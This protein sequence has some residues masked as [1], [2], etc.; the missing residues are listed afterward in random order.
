MRTLVRDLVT[1]AAK[2]GVQIVHI[3]KCPRDQ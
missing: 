3:D 2:L 1:P